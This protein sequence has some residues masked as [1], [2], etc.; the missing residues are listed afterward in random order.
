MRQTG[1]MHRTRFCFRTPIR[2]RCTDPS[3]SSSVD[4]VVLVRLE[5]TQHRAQPLPLGLVLVN[6][7]REPALSLRGE[8]EHCDAGVVLRSL[9]LDQA[10]VLGAGDEVG[11]GRLR[12]PEAGGELR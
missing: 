6:R 4:G 1:R 2:E 9:A 5:R 3:A 12:E 10:G 7:A 11:D 8:A